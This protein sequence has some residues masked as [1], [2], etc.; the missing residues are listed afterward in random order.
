MT[1]RPRITSWAGPCLDR[2][3]ARGRTAAG[4]IVISQSD[5]GRS[6]ENQAICPTRKV[7]RVAQVP[8]LGGRVFARARPGVPVGKETTA[9]NTIL[10]V[11][12]WSYQRTRKRSDSEGLWLGQ[13][14]SLTTAFA[15]R[16]GHADQSVPTVPGP[17]MWSGPQTAHHPSSPPGAEAARP[18][19]AG[20]SPRQ[21]CSEPIA[22]TFTVMQEGLAVPP[23]PMLRNSGTI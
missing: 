4:T 1:T 9:G 8:E 2:Q 17:R 6:T 16:F 13:Q 19:P 20:R 10:Q 11:T 21:R 18:S 22:T 12:C 5:T 23:G 15:N 14:S 7:S 3:C